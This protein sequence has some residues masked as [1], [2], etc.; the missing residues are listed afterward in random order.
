[1]KIDD[2][3]QTLTYFFN[4]I[5][6]AV[7]PGLVFG[8]GLL[9]IHKDWMTAAELKGL[10][11]NGSLVTA[12]I[13]VS[14]AAGHILLAVYSGAIEPVLKKIMVVKGDGVTDALRKRQSYAL[15]ESLVEGQLK[16]H[17][18]FK[19]GVP[20]P[21]WGF[22]DLRNVALSISSEGSAL[23][24]RF[25]FISLLCCGVGTALLLLGADY[26]ACVLFAPR[27]LASYTNAFPPSIQLILILAV[28]FL[29]IRRGDTFYARAMFTPF[30][31]ATTTLLMKDAK[32]EPAA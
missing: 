7:I 17:P 31:I 2:A 16:T 8:T 12:L 18:C 10:M 6:G 26:L 32:N 14:F 13:A 20:T 5:I 27:A 15:F 30:G 3:L 19:A 28:A 22:H 21:N 25:M 1:M 9:V 4:D 24:R 11:A 23:G 29:C